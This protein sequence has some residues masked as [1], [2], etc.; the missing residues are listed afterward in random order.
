MLCKTNGVSIDN[1]TNVIKAYKKPGAFLRVMNGIGLAIQKLGLHL[2]TFG[3]NI[4]SC[5]TPVILAITIARPVLLK[6]FD[7]EKLKAWK[8]KIL[9]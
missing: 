8:R 5:P 9:K 1:Q 6:L 4:H 2:E 7:Y 3:H